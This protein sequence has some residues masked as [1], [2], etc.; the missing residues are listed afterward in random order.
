M[1]L[2]EKAQKFAHEAHDSINQKR[3]YTGEPYWVHTDE[4]AALVGQTPGST[5]EMGAASHLHDVLEDVMP[6]NPH[7]NSI[8]ILNE[9]GTEVLDLVVDLTDVYTKAQYPKWNRATRHEKENARLAQVNTQ[10]KTIKLAD[11]ICNTYSI[12]KHDP[13]FARIYL[14]EKFALLPLLADGAPTLLERASR[15]VLEGF[16]TLGIQ[17]PVF[18]S[19]QR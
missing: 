11:L 9:F 8:R 4:V 14:R 19:G 18:T 7:Y 10:A 15:Q 1:N 17:L 5:P 12:V 2:V 6:L 3:K 13:D 16:A